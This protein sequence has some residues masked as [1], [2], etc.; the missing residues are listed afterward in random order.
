VF[1][2]YRYLSNE[3]YSPLKEGIIVYVNLR[4]SEGKV[5]GKKMKR[6]PECTGRG[7]G[8]I[9]AKRVYEGK[10]LAIKRVKRRRKNINLGGE[11]E[12]GG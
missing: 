5:T 3:K 4:E 7:K 9:M 11:S 1:R 12:G 6:K 2:T 10:T 8:V